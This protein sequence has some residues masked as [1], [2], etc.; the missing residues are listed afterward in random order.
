MKL[1]LD[2][3]EQEADGIRKSFQTQNLGQSQEFV[4]RSFLI[5]EHLA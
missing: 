4:R 1:C 2:A 3:N 5:N